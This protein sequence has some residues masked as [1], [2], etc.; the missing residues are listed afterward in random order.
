MRLRSQSESAAAKE[1][2]EVRRGESVGAEE[3]GRLDDLVR[4]E[5][6]VGQRPGVT[7]SWLAEVHVLRP[8]D[9]RRW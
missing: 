4:T 3:R 2:V 9:G 7:R 5:V 6:S 8:M 1:V